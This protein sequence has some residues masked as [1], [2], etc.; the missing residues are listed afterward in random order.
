MTDDKYGVLYRVTTSIPFTLP[1]II[2]EFA[3]TFRAWRCKESIV[4]A[5]GD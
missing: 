2:P 5:E 3:T 4:V 1:N